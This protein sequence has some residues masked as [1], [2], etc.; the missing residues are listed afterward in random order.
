MAG[1]DSTEHLKYSTQVQDTKSEVELIL[2]CAA[3]FTT[4]KNVYTMPICPS[5]CSSLGLGW[6]R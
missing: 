4:P 5:Q 2:A 6:K 3:M 1:R